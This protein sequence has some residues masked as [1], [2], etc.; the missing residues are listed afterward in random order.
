MV[1]GVHVCAKHVQ[2]VR[3][4]ERYVE[5]LSWLD[6]GSEISQATNRLTWYHC[7]QL[8]LTLKKKRASGQKRAMY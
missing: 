2:Y 1:V 6:L 7:L 4:G 3:A 5:L 8:Y